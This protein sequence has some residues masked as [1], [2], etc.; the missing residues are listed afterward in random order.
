MRHYG[1]VPIAY[2]ACNKES[3][4]R[5]YGKLTLAV[6]IYGS[7]GKLR[8]CA[9]EACGSLV[10]TESPHRQSAWSCTMEMVE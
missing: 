10:F 4:R 6:L 1:A 9:A 7:A 5:I 8:S 3:V 2:F